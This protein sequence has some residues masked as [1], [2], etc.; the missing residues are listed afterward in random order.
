MPA[1]FWNYVKIA[2]RKINK[3]KGFSFINIVG[4]AVG[5][6]SCIMILLWVRDEISY[7]RFH[8][9]AGAIHRVIVHATEPGGGIESFAVLP[10]NL[11][12]AL[13]AE[14]PEVRQMT[15]YI[16]VGQQVV[17]NDEKKFYEKNIALADPEFLQMF[18]FPLRRG[19]AQTALSDPHSILLS[20]AAALKYFGKEDPLGKNLRLNNRSDYTV[21]GI[22]A[23]IPEQSSLSFDIL[24][25]FLS[26][27]DFGFPTQT[28]GRFSY[29][30]FVLL[31]TGADLRKLAKKIASRLQKPLADPGMTF[32][33]QPLLKIHLYS[34]RISEGEARG[35]V[36]TVFLFSVL[37]LFILLMACVNYLNL[38]TAQGGSRGKEIALRK[39][40]GAS[41]GE[42]AG[43]FLGEAV[44]QTALAMVIALTAIPLVLPMFNSL[45]GKN[46]SLQPLISLSTWVLLSGF[47][48]ITGLLA[49]VYPASYL[50]SLKPAAVLKGSSNRSI[51]GARLRKL[52][53]VFQFGLTILLVIGSLTVFRQLRF[54]QAQKLGFDKDRVLMLP[55]RGDLVGQAAALK[56][57]ILRNPSFISASAASDPAMMFRTSITIEN[58][59]GKKPGEKLECD[60]VWCDEDYCKTYG[61]EMAQGQFFSRAMRGSLDGKIVVNE[62]A[63]KA[64]GFDSPIGKRLDNR[65]IIGVVRDF[66]THSLHSSIG[67]VVMAHDP[68]KFRYLF[69]K[70][71]PGDARPALTSLA[72]TWKRVA[73][74]YP[75]DF[76]FL[77][78][79][80]DNLYRSD[81]K[82]GGVINVFTFL[83][84]L[85][86]NMGLLGMASYLIAR[87]RK[88]IGMRKVLG[89][90]LAQIM[91]M[92]SR[93]FV[94]WVAL[95]SLL[96]CP[97]AFYVM[98]QWLHNFAYRV[99]VGIGEFVLAILLTLLIALFTIS[100]QSFRAARANPVE[101]LRYE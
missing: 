94:K 11:G 75:L 24:L 5:L 51:G 84:L 23:D 88:E 44:L 10:P 93:E 14:F 21:N 8:V 66:H 70:I 48:L 65:E 42:I 69:V 27:E 45:S 53:V 61:I 79:Q 83:A 33:L 35:S 46:I 26:A 57:E 68:A 37:A 67:P 64:L 99:S 1:L 80:L 78:Q 17:A 2:L 63:V 29:T 47:L 52:L 73:P 22:L 30:T 71:Q 60:F 87:R 38:T 100:S 50:S 74:D 56:T 39:V 98:S 96:A 82:L 49:G 59:E 89:A 95:A 32:S 34:A 101:S 3:Q 90:T 6:C 12:P 62:S 72:G 81:H 28:W 91:V 7:D 43:Q 25:P 36:E 77:D 20:E 9:H 13:K 15:R 92:L 4:L 18:S 85:I 31:E 16:S 40:T 55:L 41:R 19:N 58:W 76:T 86:A 54:V 97:L